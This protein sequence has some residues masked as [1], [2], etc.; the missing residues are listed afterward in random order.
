VGGGDRLCS[1]EIG[2]R[3]RH[4]QHPLPG[5]PRESQTSHC[6]R[7]QPLGDFIY[8]APTLH[9]RIGEPRVAGSLTLELHAPRTRHALGGRCRG[10]GAL[11]RGCELAGG[12][13]R[14]LDVHVEPVE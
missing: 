9:G 13:A 10:L 4:F 14:D 6:V 5:P 12:Q 2:D 11:A 1:C 8:L 7:Q 3:A